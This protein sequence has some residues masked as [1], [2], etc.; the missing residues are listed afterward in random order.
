MKLSLWQ[1]CLLPSLTFA[2]PQQG[3]NPLDT[4]PETGRGLFQRSC[5]G[6]HG[7][8]ARGGRGP[9]LTTGKW[10]WGGSDADILHNIQQGIP[11]TQMPAFP[12]AENEARAILAFLR[13]VQGQAGAEPVTGDPQKGGRLF[14]GA[15]QCSRCHMFGGRGGRLG[16]DLTWIGS[17]KAAGELRRAINSPD[18]SLRENFETV[19]AEFPDGKVI[20]GVAK[21]S[22]TFSIQILDKQEQLH[23]LLKRDLKRVTFTHKSLMPALKLP[24]PEVEDLIA[25]LVK[26]SGSET[27]FYEGEFREWRPAKDLNVSFSRLKNAPQEPGNWLTYWGNYEGTHYSALD[28]IAPTNVESIRSE[29][30]Y[31]FGGTNVE[32]TPLVVGGLMFVTGALNNAAALDARTGATVWRYTRRLPEG[33]HNQCTVMTNRGLAILGDRLYMATLDAHLVSLDAK[34]GNV[35][36]DVAVDDYKKGFSITHAPLALDGKIIVGVTSGEC[37]L[38]GFID[39][40]DAASGK[41]LWRFWAVAQKGDPARSTWAGDSADYGGGPTWMT[42]T[43][44]VETDTLFWTTGNPGP[45]YD[46][47]VREGDNLYT[48]SVLALDPNT[49]KLKWYFQFTPH[50]T[51]DWDANETPVLIDAQFRSRPRKLLIQA[52][53]NGFYYVLDR[54]TGE[55]LLGKSFANQN[56]AEGLDDRGRPIVR[57]NT[58]PTPKGTY[59]CP[60]ASGNTNW[61]APSYNSQTG[62]LYVAVRE[63]CALYIS[64][65]RPPRPGAPYTGGDPQVDP[66]VGTPGFVRAIDPLTGDVRWSFP[67]QI[68]SS[69]AGVLS[70][71]SGLVFAASQDGYLIALDGSTGKELWHYQTGAQI[72]SSPISYQVDGKQKVAIATSSSL[73]TFALP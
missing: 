12:M 25:F 16:P 55:F 34:T 51:H 44:D 64:E 2:A 13:R 18:E 21:N 15:A 30:A 67:L 10:R 36:W 47:S 69:S 72:Q 5:S 60:D 24:R 6:C 42:G 45:D 7:E 29:W 33:V 50:D 23:L 9:D 43:Y 31:Q 57:P 71:A 27:G 54:L 8:N 3:T 41:K 14:F 73:L 1:L 63:A 11:G 46:G 65:T 38:T 17:E 32:T 39:G 28:S 22:D 59:V 40:Y 19:E 66:K 58:D 62:L 26:S 70:T 37:A 48:C 61:A 35:I 4:S 68:G 53:R 52:N 20:R 49:G 56:W